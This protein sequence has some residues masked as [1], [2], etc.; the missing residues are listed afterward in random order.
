MTEKKEIVSTK[1]EKNM[2]NWLLWMQLG[3][4][5]GCHQRPDR[6][7]FYKGYQFPVCARCTGVFIGYILA[8]LSFKFVA[9]GYMFCV[10]INIP[11]LI[12]GC[13][14]LLRIRESNQMLRVTTGIMSGYGILAFQL[15]LVS[16]ILF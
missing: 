1:E 6:S 2:R 3:A 10:V 4:K 11:M 8:M 16:Q 9:V 5:T 15:K 7:F 12:D 14:Q 13:T